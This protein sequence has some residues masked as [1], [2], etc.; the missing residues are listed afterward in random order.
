MPEQVLIT[1]N[2]I[3]KHEPPTESWQNILKSSG[4]GIAYDKPFPLSLI[5]DANIDG[6][7]LEDTLWCFRCLPEYE[8]RF[9]KFVTSCKNT[10]FNLLEKEETRN[11]V[12][13]L[14]KYLEGGLTLEELQS[15]FDITLE[16]ITKTDNAINDVV[17]DATEVNR[18]SEEAQDV[19]FITTYRMIENPTS[20]EQSTVSTSLNSIADKAEK[21]ERQRQIDYLYKLLDGEL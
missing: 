7:G 5:L 11:C 10:V 15:T 18:V 21:V 19:A 4:V 1:L 3:R 20:N 2:Q 17:Y 13:M 14:G 16:A 12:R 8:S 6:E 9:L